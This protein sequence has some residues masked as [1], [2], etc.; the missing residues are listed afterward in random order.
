MTTKDRRTYST[1]QG[2]KQRCYNPKCAQYKN[3]GGRGITVCDEWLNSFAAFVRDMGEKPEGFSIDRIDNDKGYSKE[4]CRWATLEEQ[5]R[6]QR[7][8]VYLEYDGKRMT[9]R[10]WAVELGRHET[11]IHSRI[12]RGYP[13]ELVLAKDILLSGRVS[14]KEAMQQEGE[15]KP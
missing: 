12:R 11:T 4:N 10:E 13:L 15:G 14:P 7:R 8:S 3:Y 5:A 2:M 9:M 6:N 1:W